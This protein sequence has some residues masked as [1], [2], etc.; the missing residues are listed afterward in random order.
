MSPNWEINI[1]RSDA[2]WTQSVYW[3]VNISDTV[4][5]YIKVV[6]RVIFQVQLAQARCITIIAIRAGSKY[7][8]A[9]CGQNIF[10]H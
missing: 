9:M 5:K 1:V 7:F 8:D 4:G 6:Y 2:L 3:P 10:T